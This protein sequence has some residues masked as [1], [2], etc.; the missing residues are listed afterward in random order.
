MSE[1]TT[2]NERVELPENI[3]Q[4]MKRWRQNGCWAEVPRSYNDFHRD[5]ADKAAEKVKQ[6]GFTILDTSIKH[7]G[8][9]DHLENLVLKVKSES[10]KVS[11]ISWNDS[12]QW[13]MENM[14]S[15]GRGWLPRDLKS[16]K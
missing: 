7:D 3:K 12:N 13:F 15:G 16:I 4:D 11:T 5:L 8:F 9:G 6:L 1:T 2:E 10:G 14:P